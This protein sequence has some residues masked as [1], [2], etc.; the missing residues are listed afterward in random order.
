MEKDG[1]NYKAGNKVIAKM[2]KELSIKGKPTSWE[3]YSPE[4]I[5]FHEW[6]AGK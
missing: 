3:H 4:L 2:L 1:F 6:L 5:P